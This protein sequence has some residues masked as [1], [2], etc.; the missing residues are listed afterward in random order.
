MLPRRGGKW[1]SARGLGNWLGMSAFP[2]PSFVTWHKAVGQ[3]GG[4]YPGPLH[5]CGVGSLKRWRRGRGCRVFYSHL[6]QRRSEVKHSSPSGKCL[7]TTSEPCFP[8]PK[9]SLITKCAGK[10]PWIIPSN[11]KASC[12]T[13]HVQF[14]PYFLASYGTK[15]ADRLVKGEIAG[16]SQAV[17]CSCRCYVICM[18]YTSFASQQEKFRART[19]RA[20]TA[21]PPHAVLRESLLCVNLA[22]EMGVCSD[23]NAIPP[24]WRCCF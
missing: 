4:S 5:V 22:A 9:K 24:I 3:N 15:C 16:R 17:T 11:G 1:H 8:L 14:F 10:V 23:V 12:V 7:G 18:G 6:P 13:C 20:T 21:A 2:S 19:L